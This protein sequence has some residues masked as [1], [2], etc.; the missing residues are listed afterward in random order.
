MTSFPPVV[1]NSGPLMALAK[2]NS[3]YLLKELYGCIR[4]TRAVYDETV[5]EGLRQGYEDARTLQLF[6]EQMAWNPEDVDTATAPEALR[7]ASLDHGERDTLVLALSAGKALVLVDETMAREVARGLGLPTRGTLGIL[8]DA[9]RRNLIST[10][11]LRLYC[12]EIARRPDI[13]ISRVLVER[14]LREVLGP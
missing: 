6:L 9:Y 1:S 8:V 7:T 14:V 5:A 3:L 12:A 4:F 13:W 11:Q 10:D 2:L